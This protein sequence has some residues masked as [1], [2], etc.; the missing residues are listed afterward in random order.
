MILITKENMNQ[1]RK[2]S[3][4][5]CVLL[6]PFVLNSCGGGGSS[7]TPATATT[8]TPSPTGTVINGITVPVAPDATLNASTLKGV[9][10]N[11]NGVRDDVEITIV[12]KPISNQLA[13]DSIKLAKSYEAFLNSKTTTRTDAL[14]FISSIHCAVARVSTSDVNILELILNTQD[15]R[16]AYQKAEALLGGY[17]SDE[18][19][20]CQ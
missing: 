1:L 11:N 4:V 2:I 14:L 20:V 5:A 3:L 13:T 10:S 8:S 16:L 6:A 17:S 18:L 15:R 7:S 12:S 9:D 19:T